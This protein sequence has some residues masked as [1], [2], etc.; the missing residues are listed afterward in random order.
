MYEV[1]VEVF[2]RRLNVHPLRVLAAWD[3][4]KELGV[5]MH[6]EPRKGGSS[7]GRHELEVAVFS[8][9]GWTTKRIDLEAFRG[10]HDLNYR[11]DTS[12]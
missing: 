3:R 12:E 9:S 1:L 7:S 8:S 6:F 10:Y 2:L 11:G 5:F 4:M